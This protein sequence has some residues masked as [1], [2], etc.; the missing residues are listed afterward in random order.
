MSSTRQRLSGSASTTGDRAEA[1]RAERVD[2]TVE[3]GDIQSVSDDATARLL[4]IVLVGIVAAV[5]AVGLVAAA[6]WAL[7]ADDSTPTLGTVDIGYLQ[8]MIDHHEQALV[9]SNAYLDNNPNGDAA[10]YASEVIMFQERD[11]DRMEAMLAEAGF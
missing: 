10:P 6:Q 7:S 4:R 5:V 3:D 1:R 11:I 2:A 9:I 8:D